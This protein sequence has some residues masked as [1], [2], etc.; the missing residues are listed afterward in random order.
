MGDPKT[1]DESGR[2]AALRAYRILDTPAELAYDELTELAAQICGCPVAVMGLVDETRDWKKSKYGLP[3]SFTG[4][5]RQ[6]SICSTTICGNDLLY[7][8]DLANDERLSDNPCVTGEP[9]LR[10]YCGMP[11]INSEGYALG[12]LCVIDFEPRTL[13]FEQQEA[14]RRL[15]RQIVAQLELRR[16]LFAM[17][18]QVKALE[19]AGVAIAAER[20]RADALL[21]N[22]LPG[23]VAEELKASNQVTP[24]FYES[25]TVM[26]TDFCGFTRLTERMDPKSLIDQLDE[27][28]SAFDAIAGRHR[29]E[30]LKTIGDAYMCAGGLPDAQRTHP[31]DACLA[32]IEFQDFIARSNQQRERLRL[33]RW[34]IR[35]GLHTGPVIAGVVGRRKFT[36]DVWGDAVNVAARM[37]SSGEAGAINVS[38]ATM[39]RVR[40]LFEFADRGVLEAKGKGAMPMYRLL[41]IRPELSRDAAG[42]VPGPP[43]HAACE[44]L[45]AGY[46]AAD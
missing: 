45:F 24:R 25:A 38:E 19:Q 46:R 7:A 21:K 2:L 23:K 20:D 41:R 17:D 28:F 11:L 34:D 31:V 8:P 14:I 42:R 13:A 43:F 12:T 26:F 3:A 30:K 6:V 36:Y 5:P 39:N 29:L 32:A 27:Y 37:E 33:P 44:T 22:I 18:D 10:M 9:H 16:S 35:I 40:T 1:T 4:M 15:A